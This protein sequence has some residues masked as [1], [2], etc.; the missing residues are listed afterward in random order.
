MSQR[1]RLLGR[2]LPTMRVKIRVDFS[3]EADE[4]VALHEAALRDLDECQARGADLG[5]AAARVEETAA[6]VEPL[7][8]TLTVSPLA[9]LEY[10]ALIQAHPPTEQQQGQGYI[11]NPEGFMPALMAAC[12]GRDLPP[13]DRMTE[14]DWVSLLTSASAASAGE[15]TALYGLCVRMNDRAPDLLM[16]KEFG[17]TPS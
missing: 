4:L 10:E 3:A 7:Y 9:P 13:E 11:W 1:E 14:K 15:L 8:E 17:A 12:I 6:A 16:G 5:E 2:R